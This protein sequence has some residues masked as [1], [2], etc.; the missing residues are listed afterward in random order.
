MQY[1]HNI[2]LIILWFCPYWNQG[3]KV[4]DGEQYINIWKFLNIFNIPNRWLA[5]CQ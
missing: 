5:R 2:F 3:E 1:R 4:V